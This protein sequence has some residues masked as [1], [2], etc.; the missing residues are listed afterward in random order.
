MKLKKSI[1]TIKSRDSNRNNT[2]VTA[3]KQNANK[4]SQKSFESDQDEVR[5]NKTPKKDIV[6]IGDSLIKYMN[7]REI[8][9]SSSVKIR[10]H[11]DETT[12]DL[13]D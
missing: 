6:I 4:C 13:I 11:Q 10:S 12:D 3:R 1:D 7:G 2:N 5:D 8:S 9:R